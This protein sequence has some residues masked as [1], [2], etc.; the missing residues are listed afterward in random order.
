MTPGGT[1]A[2]REGGVGV[3]SQTSWTRPSS[4][5]LPARRLPEH[6]RE[7]ARVA[8]MGYRWTAVLELSARREC[9]E[10]AATARKLETQARME[11]GDFSGCLTASAGLTDSETTRWRGLCRKRGG[12]E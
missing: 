7:Q 10:Q 9:W 1:S 11:T 3:P 5:S 12:S 2:R 4:E 8:Q 6:V